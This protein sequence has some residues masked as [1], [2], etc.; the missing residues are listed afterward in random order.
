MTRPDAPLLCPADDG[1]GARRSA[2]RAARRCACARAGRAR[3]SAASAASA[4][5][6]KRPR[7]SV[8]SHRNGAVVALPNS[9]S[10]N[11]PMSST[12][13]REPIVVTDRTSH[14]E[15]SSHSLAHADL[16]S[17]STSKL[18][19]SITKI[20]SSASL[21]S[22]TFECGRTSCRRITSTGLGAAAREASF[23]TASRTASGQ[24]FAQRRA[25]RR[26]AL[27]EDSYPS[28]RATRDQNAARD[29]WVDVSSLRTTSSSRWSSSRVHFGPVLWCPASIV[30]VRARAC[31]TRVTQT[32]SRAQT[33]S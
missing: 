17:L 10:S 32:A 6:P 9:A 30:S 21:A 27:H 3:A 12:E 15:R 19:K 11:S 33:R 2:R 20:C 23:G 7:R 25:H 31:T 8:S 18:A 1:I 16:L 24:S 4:A 14:V 28:R 26:F 13:L 5:S 29:G 22:S